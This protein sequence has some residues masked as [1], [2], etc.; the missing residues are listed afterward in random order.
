MDF[1]L[2]LRMKFYLSVCSDNSRKAKAVLLTSILSI[3]LK[4]QL[5]SQN[6]S[7]VGI[8]VIRS[9]IFP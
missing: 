1:H 8:R 6:N 4:I 5:I 7:F 2:P 9:A 3:P